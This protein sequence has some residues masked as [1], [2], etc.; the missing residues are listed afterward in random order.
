MTFLQLSKLC[1]HLERA[2]GEYWPSHSTITSC[3]AEK[4]RKASSTLF[5]YEPFLSPKTDQKSISEPAAHNRNLLTFP[6][7]PFSSL[8]FFFH[9]SEQIS[10]WK[11]LSSKL[12][13][14][15]KNSF[16][17]ILLNEQD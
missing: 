16:F 9:P 17:P 13:E 4:L 15:G 1:Y 10:R 7:F 8:Y 6:S 11:Q 3:Q 5:Y 2:L 12:L 14:G